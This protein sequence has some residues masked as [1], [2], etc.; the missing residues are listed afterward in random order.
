MNTA[1]SGWLARTGQTGL[2]VPLAGSDLFQLYPGLSR[3]VASIGVQDQL[4]GQFPLA[5]SG[6]HSQGSRNWAV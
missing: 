2:L 5:D 3:A 4:I 6:G 1:H